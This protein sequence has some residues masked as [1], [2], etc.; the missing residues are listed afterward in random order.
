MPG[1][2]IKASIF[3]QK[4]NEEVNRFLLSLIDIGAWNACKWM[5]TGCV[6]FE[7]TSIPPFLVIVFRNEESA[8]DLFAG[9]R[10]K[11]GQD[12]EDELIRVS[13]VEGTFHGNP[14]AYAAQIGPNIEHVFKRFEVE[15]PSQGYDQFFAMNRINCM[16]PSGPSRSL[17]LFKEQFRKTGSYFLMPGATRDGELSPIDELKIKKH[18]ILFRRKEDISA[19]DL[20][21]AV[22]K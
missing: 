14:D 21:S 4:V 9:L 10:A 3:L 15:P 16:N 5:A 22:L 13:I 6:A 2:A 17:A 12:D 19:G 8:Q 11:V 7:G 1:A 20:D 18:S